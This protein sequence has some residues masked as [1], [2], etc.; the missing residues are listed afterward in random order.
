MAARS[1]TN[2]TDGQ[3]VPAHFQCRSGQAP[4]Q[5]QTS[6]QRATLRSMTPPSLSSSYC[7]R[8]MRP[9]QTSKPRFR[10]YVALLLLLSACATPQTG[11]K[12]P[13]ARNPRL[14]N[15]RR[16]AALPWTDDGRCVLQHASRPWPTVVEQCFHAL[17]TQRIRFSDTEGR[18]SVASTDAASLQAMVGICL[19]AQPELLVGAVVVIGVVV[20]AVAIK[21]ALEAYALE[22]SYPEN[23]KPAPVPTPVTQEPSAEAAPQPEKSPSRTDP[24][25]SVEPP[26]P[27]RPECVPRPVPH[28]GGDAL[29]NHC[30]DRVPQ[31]DFPGSDVV[32]NGK[33]FDAVQIR[34][35]VLW[36]IKTDNFD[37]YTTD[38]R[39]IVLGKQV[40]E[41]RR[42]RALAMACG[43][44]FWV[45]VRS[46]AHRAALR[47]LD[48]NLNIVVMDWC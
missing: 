32:V 5:V 48:G 45:G 9:H 7:S 16:A 29:H 31:R 46:E 12:P 36:E 38:L 33:S 28:L 23:A 25:V 14:A 4:R 30:A 19:L 22:G 42:E 21:E 40:A 6:L 26:G 13:V 34:A 47:D 18:C 17:D 2:G 1:R 11:P 41:L 8:R 39:R 10:A 43:F 35:R 15:L 44:D 37:S 20:V 3:S 27:G 24:P